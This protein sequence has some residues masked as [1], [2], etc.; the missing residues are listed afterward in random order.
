M[1][2]FLIT[3]LCRITTY[4]NPTLSKK[5]HKPHFFFLVKWVITISHES[6]D[7]YN[8]STRRYSLFPLVDYIYFFSYFNVFNLHNST[9][10][11]HYNNLIFVLKRRYPHL[12]SYEFYMLCENFEKIFRILFV[13][14]TNI[15]A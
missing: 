13:K 6:C 4:Q 7:I 10:L 5:S 12:V 14:N 11:R 1:V 9:L 8:T 15:Y 3:R 2:F